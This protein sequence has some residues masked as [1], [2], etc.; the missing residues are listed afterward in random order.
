MSSLPSCLGAPYPGVGQDK[1]F[2]HWQNIL[3]LVPRADRARE[4][5]RARATRSFCQ[6]SGVKDVPPLSARN[7]LAW[8]D[9]SSE[10]KDIKGF[11]IFKKWH[12]IQ[13]KLDF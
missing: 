8:W 3:S 4:M 13:N 2:N 6:I 7:V 9:N 1:S 12:N 5:L 11:I 10:I